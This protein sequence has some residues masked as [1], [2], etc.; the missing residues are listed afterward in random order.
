VDALARRPG[1]LNRVMRHGLP[2]H[3][4]GAAHRAEWNVGM[5]GTDPRAQ[6]DRL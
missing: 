2:R 6:G 5:P 3:T 1:S 4:L